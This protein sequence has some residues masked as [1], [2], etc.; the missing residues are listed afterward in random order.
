[1]GDA[2]AP[3]ELC[4][5][6]LTR[7]DRAGVLKGRVLVGGWCGYFYKYFFS[8]LA[9]PL[10]P[11]EV[12]FAA[13]AASP[14][15]QASSGLLEA[16]K[17]AGFSADI[18]CDGYVRLAHRDLIVEFLVPTPVKRRRLDAELADSMDFLLTDP[19]TVHAAGL[20]VK[21]AHPVRFAFQKLIL[22]RRSRKADKRER[23]RRQAV[24]TLDAVFGRG[25][26]EQAVS[27]FRELPQ[28]WKKAVTAGLQ[29]AGRAE[30]ARLL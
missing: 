4:R 14:T 16:M 11:R 26:G 20:A 28:G 21:L 27:V 1:M 13:V 19:V 23:D 10:E 12:D 8:Y 29:D 3:H 5:E 15:R 18:L 6:L 24:E 2:A 9:L 7:L 22:S 30:L 17:P 25:E